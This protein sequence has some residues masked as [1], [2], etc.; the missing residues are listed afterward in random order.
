MH[1]P[2]GLYKGELVDGEKHGQGKFEYNDGTYH[3]GQFVNDKF[4]T[5]KGTIKYSDGSIYEGNFSTG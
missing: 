5:G 3:E 4:D 2:D 1:F